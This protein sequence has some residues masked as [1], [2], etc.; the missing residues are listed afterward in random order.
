MSH[1]LASVGLKMF[2][3]WH[4]VTFKKKSNVSVR[5]RLLGIAE[6]PVVLF[7]LCRG[8]HLIQNL[9]FSNF[10]APSLQWNPFHFSHCL[11]IKM[12]DMLCK[13]G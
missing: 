5:K 10:R 6:D 12:Q 11:K 3:S 4:I 13:R 1:L 2:K 7:W 8:G 9:N